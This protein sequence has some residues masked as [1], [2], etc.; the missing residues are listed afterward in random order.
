LYEAQRT[1]EMQRQEISSDPSFSAEERKMA[2]EVLQAATAA[3][4]ANT[5]GQQ[6]TN[7]SNGNGRWIR[8]LSAQTN[9]KRGEYR[10]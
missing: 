8:Q 6:F 3:S 5:L 7:Y 4:V 2:L 10:R 1:A 9:D